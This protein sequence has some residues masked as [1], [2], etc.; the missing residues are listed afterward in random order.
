VTFQSAFTYENE[1]DA[2]LK[3]NSGKVFSLALAEEIKH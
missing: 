2:A 1:K 3:Q